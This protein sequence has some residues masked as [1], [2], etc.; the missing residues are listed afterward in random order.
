M[1]RKLLSPATR[2]QIIY[3]HLVHPIDKHRHWKRWI[4]TSIQQ[5]TILNYEIEL[6]LINFK[7]QTG[8]VAHSI[9]W[10]RTPIQPRFL[11]VFL[12]G[13]ALVS[14]KFCISV[15]P[16]FCTNV[17]HLL[18]SLF[19]SFSLYSKRDSKGPPTLSLFSLSTYGWTQ[20]PPW[21]G[22]F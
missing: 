5:T 10:T 2:P 11:I 14:A 1:A 4:R 12:Y 15:L 18:T 9:R 22:P 7:P 8:V 19:L 16:F 17:G 13:H 21:V 3:L 6:R 20:R